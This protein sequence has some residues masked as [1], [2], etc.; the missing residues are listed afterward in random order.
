MRQV[1]SYM[2]EQC[3]RY[4]N[5]AAEEETKSLIRMADKVQELRRDFS[6]EDLTDK[7]KIRTYLEN[8][9]MTGLIVTD[10]AAGTHCVCTSDGLDFDDWRDTLIRVS[11]STPQRIHTE[12][13]TPGDG[14][15]YD[16]AVTARTDGVSGLIFGYVRQTAENVTGTRLSVRTLLDGYNFDVNG[17]VAVTDGVTVIG[18][19]RT[20]WNGIAA[21][22]CPLV[23]SARGEFTFGTLFTVHFN[24]DVYY[25]M[26]SKGDG[27]FFYVFLP[28]YD[29]M[30]NRSA[31]LSYV[32]VFY[33]VLVGTVLWFLQRNKEVQAK[34]GEA[35]RLRYSEEMDKWQGIPSVPTRRRQ[36]FCD[37]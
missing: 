26:R 14:Y 24:G 27:V 20:E 18:S 34:A 36:T 1:L 13:Y 19:N 7:D 15:Y 10:N 28:S 23:S 12:R 9:R 16:F 29:V 33:F 2:E 4:D 30:R 35:A 31:M 11:A 3:I 21:E 17:I 25:T 32:L 8:Q 6:A 5:V 37:A 22:D